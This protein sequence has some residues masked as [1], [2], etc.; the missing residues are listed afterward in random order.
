MIFRNISTPV[1]TTLRVSRIA[2]SLKQL[3]RDTNTAVIAISD[4]TKAAYQQA[5]ST[6]SLDMSALRD[7]FKIAHAADV[8]A[9]LQSGKIKIGKG[10]NVQTLDQLELAARNHPEKRRA[11][12]KA[13]AESRL[14]NRDTFSRLSILKNRGGMTAEPLFIY[15]KAQHNFEPMNLELGEINYDEI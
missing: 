6:G 14:G 5:I 7:S 12:D 10:D 4:I 3:A 9:L 2:T 8:I 15:R 13:R 11:L 1:T